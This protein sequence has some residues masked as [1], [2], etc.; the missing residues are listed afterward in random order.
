MSAG[1][2]ASWQRRESAGP[3]AS[4]KWRAG[5]QCAHKWLDYT[6]TGRVLRV[7]HVVDT[8]IALAHVRQFYCCGAGFVS[9]L[10]SGFNRAIAH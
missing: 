9:L 5:D 3:C 4:C 1:T 8:R 10:E 7:I 2:Y 6:E